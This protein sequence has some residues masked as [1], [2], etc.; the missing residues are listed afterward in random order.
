[1]ESKVCVNCKIEKSIDNFTTNK[2]NVNGVVLRE[3]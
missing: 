3:A 2:E 1:M